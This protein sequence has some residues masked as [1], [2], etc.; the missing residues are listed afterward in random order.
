LEKILRTN[1]DP[2]LEVFCLEMKDASQLRRL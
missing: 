1:C 2:R